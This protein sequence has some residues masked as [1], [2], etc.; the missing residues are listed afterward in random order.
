MTYQEWDY[1]FGERT[2]SSGIRF[3]K[4]TVNG[5]SGVIL[6]PDDWNATLYD[7][8]DINNG[9]ADYINNNITDNDWTNVFEPAGAVFLPADGRMSSGSIVNETNS[10]YDYGIYWS[11]SK[12]NT[13][14]AYGV[15]FSGA[16]ANSGAFFLNEGS[17]S[18]TSI[19]NRSY[20]LSVRLVRA[21]NGTTPTSYNIN[22]SANPANGGTLSGG[23]TYTQGSNCTV[24]AT[25]NSGYTFT[26]WTENGNPV[27]TSASYTFTVVGDRT[28]VANFSYNGGNSGITGALDGVF[29]VSENS[30]VNFSQGN[31]QYQASTNTW[32]F[33]PNQYDCVGDANQSISQ[34]NSGWIDLLGWGTS[35]Y[36]HGA[37]CY[38]PWSTSTNNSDYYPYGS[39]ISN[40]YNQTGQAD[41]GYNAIANGGNQENCGWRTLTKDEWDYLFNSRNTANGIRFAKAQVN[42][43]NGVILL[44]DD[45][46]ANYY[47][48]NNTNNESADFASNTISASQWNTLDQHGAVFLAAAGYRN[49]ASVENVSYLGAYWSSS[50]NNSSSVYTVF[51]YSSNLSTSEKNSRRFGQSVRLVRVAQNY[52]YMINGISNSSEGG[53]VSGGGTYAGGSVCTLTA[54][55]NEGYTFVNWTENGNTVSINA[56]YTFTVVGDRTLVA[57]FSN[58]GGNSSTGVLKSVFSVS[59]NSLVN[60]SQG[61]LQYQASTNTWRF[62]TNQYDYVGEANQSISQTYSGWIDLFGWGTSG[63]NHGAVCYQPWSTSTNESDYYVYGQYTFNLYDQTGQADWGYNAISNGGNQENSGWRTLTRDEWGYLLNSRNTA[64]GIRYAKAQVNGVN[65]VIILPDDWNADYYV[66]NSP[67]NK[68]ASFNSNIV[69]ASQWNTFDQHGAVFLPAAGYRDGTTVNTAGSKGNYWSASY[70]GYYAGTIYFIDGNLNTSTYSRNCGHSVRLVRSAQNYSCMINATPNPVEGGVVSGGGPYPE[71]AECTLTATPNAGYTFVNWTKNGEVVSTDNPLVFAVT[72][73]AEFV[74]NFEL[75]TVTQTINLTSGANWVS[76]YVEITLDDLKAALLAALPDAGANSIVIKSKDNGSTTYRG[77]GSWRGN[78]NA[79]DLSQSYRITVGSDCVIMLEGMPIDPASLDININNGVNWIP[80]PF[81]ANMTV[82]NAF[83]GF[84]YNIDQVKTKINS[85]STTYKGS[86]R[87]TLSTLVPGQG[88]VHKSA[89]TESRT[90]H[91]PTS[92]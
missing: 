20:A 14:R 56:S 55:A 48:L 39:N 16:R 13:D 17:L 7:L 58:N 73:D 4:A 79:L 59:E 24:T 45:W 50:Y 74:A 41:W 67:N 64:N 62:A 47:V 75:S 34:T 53:E 43:V 9:S 1:L 87:G 11:S 19:I 40:L 76:T 89:K 21:A 85:S 31:L 8:E 2:T 52:S 54:T 5:V 83:A 36:D 32:R 84:A 28:L 18:A 25:A 78:L 90:F 65:G 70:S 35:G 63:Y 27:S 71:G 91:F 92:K 42:G 6:F 66:L 46:N 33:A 3:A 88:Y 29:S 10:D 81:D 57:N 80:F 37:V 69:S 86:W 30:H 77:S 68:S 51:F 38:Q 49:G 12:Y 23:G 61:N 72:E 60:F 15:R 26:N 82:A 44:P 22:V